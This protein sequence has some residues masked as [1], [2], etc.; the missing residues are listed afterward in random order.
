MDGCVAPYLGT[1]GAL[2]GTSSPKGLPSPPV[3]FGKHIPEDQL[4]RKGPS[5]YPRTFQK[6]YPK[7]LEL[8]KEA[9]KGVRTEKD[10]P[11]TP[12][13]RAAAT[14]D[15]V[16]GTV[17]RKSRGSRGAR[18]NLSFAEG[19]VPWRPRARLCPQLRARR[20][21]SRLGGAPQ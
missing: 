21:E 15:R 16:G 12:R 1:P 17:S 8:E 2:G 10:A 4:L 13:L 11:C 9:R 20:G 7:T 14:D 6:S 18:S 3:S 5:L 19:H